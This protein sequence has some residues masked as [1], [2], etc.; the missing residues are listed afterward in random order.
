[1]TT[2]AAWTTYP[3]LQGQ[4]W[5]HYSYS[6]PWSF[7]ETVDRF[8]EQTRTKPWCRWATPTHLIEE[9]I[10]GVHRHLIIHNPQEALPD[11]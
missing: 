11:L 7:R 5:N 8:H 2:G 3:E 1:M 9:K 10:P 4:E 6:W